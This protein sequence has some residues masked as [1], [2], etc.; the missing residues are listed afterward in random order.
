MHRILGRASKQAFGITT[1]IL[2]KLIGATKEDLRGL[3]DRALLILAYDSLC[4]R[5][6]LTSLRIDDIEWDDAGLPIRMRLRRSKTDQEAIGK[7][8]RLEANA[9]TAIRI[10][11]NS[12][13][14]VEGFL[15]RGVKNNGD[16]SK[17]ICPGQINRIYKRLAKAANLSKKNI[18]HISGHSMR[19]GAAQDLLVSG[20]SLPVIMTKGRWSKSDTVMRYVE[21]YS[22]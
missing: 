9:Q 20:A 3:R 21:N 1:P 2:K 22:G 15:F 8:L 18:A 6:E 16:I 17:E 13:K 12:A 11:I 14:I 4:R 7:S 5:S 10:W 19:V